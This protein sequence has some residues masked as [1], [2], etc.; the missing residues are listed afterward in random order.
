VKNTYTLDWPVTNGSFK[1]RLEKATK[2]G[3]RV[4]EIRFAGYQESETGNTAVYRIVF[5]K[6][7]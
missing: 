6:S 7:E 4:R 5:I 1:P 2:L 3:Y